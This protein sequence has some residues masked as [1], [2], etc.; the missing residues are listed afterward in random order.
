MR[1]NIFTHNHP[2]GGN[3]SPGDVASALGSGVAE[4]RAFSATR[5]LSIRFETPPDK[6]LG[7]P[8][9]AVLFMDAEKAAIG[10][11][12]RSDVSTGSIVPPA[13]PIAKK[14]F[15]SDYFMDQLVARNSWIKYI[16]TPHN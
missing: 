11:R 2:L 5:T 16:S 12:Y 14:V 10:A 4:F 3:F 15:L 7:S 8:E 1:N 6:L 9:R 13:D